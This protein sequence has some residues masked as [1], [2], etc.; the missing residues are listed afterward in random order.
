MLRLNPELYLC[1]VR[2]IPFVVLQYLF[3]YILDI[4]FLIYILSLP[5]LILILIFLIKVLFFQ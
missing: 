2:F 3:G 5:Y 4:I 1:P